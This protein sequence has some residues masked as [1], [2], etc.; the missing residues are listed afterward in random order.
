M[1]SQP[2]QPQHQRRPGLLLPARRGLSAKARARA[3]AFLIAAADV[4]EQ[5]AVAGRIG[6]NTSR[7]AEM[8]DSVAQNLEQLNHASA[9]AGQAAEE[10]SGAAGA[11]EH[12]MRAL[13]SE[14]AKFVEDLRAA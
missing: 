10:V 11:L 6:R 3:A 5:S 8:T 9:T 14:I 2:G 1:P 13:G 12:G 4:E 7:S